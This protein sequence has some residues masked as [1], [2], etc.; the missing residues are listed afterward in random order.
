MSEMPISFE[1]SHISS[2][3]I[4]NFF[5]VHGVTATFTMRFG[6]I[7]V[8]FAKYDLTVGPC[9]PIG[10]FA[11]EMWGVRAGKKVSTNF[12]QAGQQLVNWGNGLVLL[13]ILS[14]NSEASSVMVK[15]AAKLVSST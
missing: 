9:I 12:T 3:R 1:A 8:F 13:T 15:S 2:L 7:P 10:D 4:S 5:A 6:S 14:T 11:L